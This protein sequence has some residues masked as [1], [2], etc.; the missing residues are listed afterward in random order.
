MYQSRQP[1]SDRRVYLRR[2]LTV[3]GVLVLLLAVIGYLAFAILRPLPA[4]A[5]TLEPTETISQTV[6]QIAWPAFG[7]GAIG[8]VGFDGVLSSTGAQE[9][10]PMA[11]ITKTVTALVVLDAMPLAAGESGPDLTLT[12]ADQRIYSEVIAE[13]GSA[14]PVAVGSVFTERQLLEAMMLPSANNYS[15]TLANWAYGSVENFLAA[16]KTWL[17]KNSLSGT[18][19]ADSSGLDPNSRS[20]PADL[21]RI[22]QMAIAHP[23]LSEIVASQSAELPVIGPVKNTNKLLGQAGVVG[24]KTGTTRVAGACLL[25]AAELPVGAQ[26]VTVVG[27]ILGA[28]N[29]SALNSSVLS[30]L[31][32]MKAGFRELPLVSEGDSF[33]SYTTPWG[34]TTDIV[35][36]ESASVLVWQDATAAV[37]VSAKPLISGAAD[38]EVGTATFTVAD[39]VIDVPL[40]LAGEL[41]EAGTGWRITHP[42]D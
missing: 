22:G 41:E 29:H 42:T 15:I 9:S 27:V 31:D 14:A 19:L 2:R 12:S 37:D 38:T 30:L 4:T 40:A 16:T 5:A 8:A 34:A 6:N 25:F 36:T 28:P 24:L 35:A 26:T 32:T 13:G 10:T 21:V 18:H 33:G 23:V 11:S 7:N 1:L 17:D 20:T 39:S 3:F